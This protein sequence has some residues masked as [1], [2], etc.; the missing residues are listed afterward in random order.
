MEK[1]GSGGRS[2]GEGE[3]GYEG[4]DEGGYEGEGEDEAGYE[5]AKRQQ[6][7]DIELP[8]PSRKYLRT[9]PGFQRSVVGR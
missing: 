9:A 5:R 3:G 8:P 2:E 4:E 6:W 7:P 1:S